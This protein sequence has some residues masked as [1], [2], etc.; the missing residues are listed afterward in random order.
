MAK[1]QLVRTL[2]LAQILML[3]IGGTM[4]AA[5]GFLLG[6]VVGAYIDLPVS[7]SI[8]LGAVVVCFAILTSALSG[9]YPAWRAS[10]LNP[11]EA[12]RSE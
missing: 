12:L 8:V 9:L 7:N 5:V 11:V 2:G 6:N 3:G 4:G 10:S 1:K